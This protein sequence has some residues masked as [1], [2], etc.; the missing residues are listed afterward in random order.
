MK[1]LTTE[2]FIDKAKKFHNNFYDYSLTNYTTAQ[3]AEKNNINLLIIKYDEN[4]EEK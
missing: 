3:Q 4:V 1:R 2:Q